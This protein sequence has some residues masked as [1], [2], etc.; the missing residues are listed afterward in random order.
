MGRK[1]FLWVIGCCICCSA[2]AQ[3]YKVAFSKAIQ[4]KDMTKAEE[5]LKAWDY[6]DSNDPDLFIAYFN[7]YTVKSLSAG[8]TITTGYD[9]LYS[10]KALDFISEG[11]ERFPTRFDMR[12]AKCYML[13]DLKKYPEYISEIIKM[14]V[15]SHKIG[16]DW[17]GEDYTL[18]DYPEEMLFGA[19][20]D[21][22]EFIFAKADTVYFKDII[23][24]SDE[25][26][27]YYPKHTQ[28]L[29]SSSTVYRMRKEYSKSLELL[30]KA[31]EIEPAN[32]IILYNVAY[33]Y[34][35]IGDLANA[36]KFFELAV[37]H[38]NEQEEKIKENAQKHLEELK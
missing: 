29:L 7:F 10:T 32:A 13:R 2:I 31:Y 4:A 19:V 22:Q 27:K 16:N 11:I 38:S 20:L 34:K 23:R 24:I 21:C 9:V 3:S 12:I 28:S 14:I 5:I 17:K 15:Y 35:T 36:K 1:F 18:L 37:T 6:A 30:K 26:L 25:M 33:V 8:Y